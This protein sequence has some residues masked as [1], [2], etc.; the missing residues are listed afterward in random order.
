MTLFSSKKNTNIKKK[1]EIKKDVQSLLKINNTESIKNFSDILL[2]PLISEKASIFS[3]KNIHTFKVNERA[4]KKDISDAI[5][6]YYKVVPLK[7][8]TVTISRKQIFIR[9]KKGFKSGYKKAYIYLK[10]SD[11]IELM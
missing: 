2:S 7:I 4:G 9:G 3:E 1:K 10:K 8:H 6:H 11:K 5:L